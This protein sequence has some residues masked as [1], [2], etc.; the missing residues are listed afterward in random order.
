MDSRV[1]A[2]IWCSELTPKNPSSHTER[3]NN[4]FLSLK[5]KKNKKNKINISKCTCMLTRLKCFQIISF[6]VLY[7]AETKVFPFFFN[8][9]VSLNYYF[10]NKI[11]F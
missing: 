8:I 7:R 6:T 2:G 11:H 10:S 5:Q 3:V 4:V 1:P 9:S